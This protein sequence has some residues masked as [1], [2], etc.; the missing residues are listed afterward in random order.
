MKFLNDIDRKVLRDLAKE[1]ADIAVTAVMTERRELWRRHN[2][3]AESRPVVY[4][5]PQGAWLE[6]VPPV[7]LLCQDEP[8][9]WI[10]D[11]LRKRIYISNHFASD[12]V[13]DSEWIVPKVPH[14][15][16]WGLT[17]VRSHSH[18]PRGAFGFKPLI[19]SPADLAK[20]K[21]PIITYDEAATLAGEETFHSLF[22]DILDVRVKGV[23]DL[24]YHLMN[25]YSALRGLQELMVD[26]IE[27]PQMVHDAMAFLEEGHRRILQQY[28][29]QNLLELNNDNT[30]IYTSGHGFTDELPAP[31]YRRGHARPCDLWGWAEAQEMASVSP[32]MHEE[33]AFPYEKRL[34]QPFGLNGYGCCDDVTQKLDF[35]LTIPNLRRV[36]VSPWADIQQCA[37]RLKDDAIL[38]WKPHP[39]H[40]VGDFNASMVRRYLQHGV[41]VARANGCALEIVLLDTHTCENHPE[42]F[43]AW[44]RIAYEAV[45][46]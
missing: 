44:S 8:A 39:A 41:D 30:P 4:I 46:G 19:S 14:N 13:V 37:Q 22:G 7:S 25:Q 31:G 38:M 20:L 23:S 35:V 45:A 6:L 17:P 29:Q 12:N 34:L 24:S 9:R 40:L 26:M 21:Y 16:G 2:A 3:M 5:D 33:F 28:V 1:V 11:N 27:N 10:E 43:D 18:D 42:R 32:E 36:S 15:S